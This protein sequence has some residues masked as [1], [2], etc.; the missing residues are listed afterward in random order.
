MAKRSF[1][2]MQQKQSV[3][4]LNFMFY[5]WSSKATKFDNNPLLSS[6]LC[7]IRL[8]VHTYKGPWY[9]LQYYI[10]LNSR[11]KRRKK[12]PSSHF[13]FLSLPALPTRVYIYVAQY[14]PPPF[15][16]VRHDCVLCF[17]RFIF[18]G[19]G[20]LTVAACIFAMASRS[21][22]SWRGLREAGSMTLLPDC[23]CF[24]KS[25]PVGVGMAWAAAGKLSRRMSI[26]GTRIW[27]CCTES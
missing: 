12:F 24:S 4:G 26:D 8:L 19:D 11:R 13:V 10:P 17:V 25:G 21:I 5:C 22:I 27:S 14:S 18:H 6:V 16:Q 1:S 3:W 2:H 15:A 23:K 9:I 7:T 20:V